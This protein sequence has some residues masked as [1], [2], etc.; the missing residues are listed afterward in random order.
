MVNLGLEL[1]DDVAAGLY[2]LRDKMDT[3]ET[4]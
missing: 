4:G 3:P 1:D 2:H